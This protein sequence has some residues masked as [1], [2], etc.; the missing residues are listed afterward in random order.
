MPNRT[1]QNLFVCIGKCETEVTNNKILIMCLMYC[2]IRP[3]SLTRSIVSLTYATHC[4]VFRSLAP[5][6]PV[7]VTVKVKVKILTLAI[8]PLTWVRLVTSSTVQSRKWQLTGMSQWCRSALC[9]R[10]LP[11]LTDN[12]TH[13]AANRHTIAPISHTRPSPRSRSYYS[14][15]IPL[16]VGG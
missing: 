14:F 1:E 12:W 7:L 3:T 2:V 10:P 16:R 11:A 6:H 5:A 9:G 15:P 8:A 13:Y 4:R